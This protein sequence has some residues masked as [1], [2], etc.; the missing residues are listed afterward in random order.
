[1]EAEPFLPKQDAARLQLQEA[2][3]LFFQARTPIGAYSLAAS[4]F[5]VTYDLAHKNGV[6]GLES[7]PYVNRNRALPLLKKHKWLW[8]R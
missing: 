5:Q 1:M 3:W 6:I 4:A 8:G 2:I 7:A